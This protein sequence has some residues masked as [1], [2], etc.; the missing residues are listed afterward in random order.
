MIAL[1]P[2]LKPLLSPAVWPFV[3]NPAMAS[4]VLRGDELVLEAKV[5]VTKSVIDKPEVLDVIAQ[6][7][8]G[9]LGRTVRVSVEAPAP[10]VGTMDDLLAMGKAWD[11]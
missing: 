5:G 10:T 11:Q 2:G 9:R 4:G 3:S 7:A 6:A 8:S 1:V